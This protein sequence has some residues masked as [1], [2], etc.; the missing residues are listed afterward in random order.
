MGTVAPPL[1]FYITSGKNSI[2]MHDRIDISSRSVHGGAMG[3][4][5]VA[6]TRMQ[7]IAIMSEELA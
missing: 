4:V 3:A 6:L 5:S 7:I 2:L 1:D